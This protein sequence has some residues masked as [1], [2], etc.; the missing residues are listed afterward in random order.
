MNEEKKLSQGIKKGIAKAILWIFLILFLSLSIIIGALQ[1]S[2][3]QTKLADYG[4]DYLT[5]KTGFGFNIDRVNIKWLDQVAL[6]G[7]TVKDR[8]SSEFIFAKDLLINYK[9]KELFTENDILIDA[10]SL[11]DARLMFEREIGDRYFNIDHFADALRELGRS[12]STKKSRKKH[13]TIDDIILNNITLGVINK[14]EDSI[15]EGFDHTHF[16]LKEVYANAHQLKA[17]GDTI[18]VQVENLSCIDSASSLTLNNITTNFEIS[19]NAMKF[20]NMDLSVNESHITDSVVFTYNSMRDLSSFTDS[21]EFVGRFRETV[22]YAKDLAYFAPE[23]KQFSEQITL[24]GTIEGK[25]KNFDASDIYLAFGTNSFLKGQIS[26]D[27]LPYVAETFIN[28]NL[29]E[30]QL[31]PNDLKQYVNDSLANA[32]LKE[33]G[34]IGFKGDFLGFPQDFVANGVFTTAIGRI[35][36][37]LNLKV[38]ENNANTSYKGSISTFNLDLGKALGRD[39][40]FQKVQMTGKINGKGLSVETANVQL[41]ASFSLLGLKGYEYQ[42]I[43]TNA[44]LSSEFFNGKLTIDDPKLDL[45]VEGSI[46]LREGLNK[47][48]VTA[49]VDTVDLRDLNLAEKELI[50]KAKGV[51]NG[52]GIRIDSIVGTAFLEQVFI[53]YDGRQLELDTLSIFSAKSNKQRNFIINSDLFRSQ[54]E[55]EFNFTTLAKDIAKLEKEFEISLRNDE[56]EIQQYYSN[57]ANI[58]DTSNYSLDISLT[59]KKLNPLVNLFVPSLQLTDSSTVKG[60]FTKGKTSVLNLTAQFDTITYGGVEFHKNEVDLTFSKQADSTNVLG[61]AYIYSAHQ[62]LPSQLSTQDIES[63]FIWSNNTIEFNSFFQ[64]PQFNNSFEIDGAINFL[65]DSTSIKVNHSNLQA[66]ESQWFFTEENELILTNGDLIFKNLGIETESQQ[67]LVNG[68]LSEDPDK[69]LA[70]QI[71]SVE[72]ANVNSLINRTYEGTLQGFITVQDYTDEVIINGDLF[73]DEFKIDNFLIGDIRGKSSWS[74]IRKR[75]AMD[76][77]INR[78][79]KDIITLKGYY[80]PKLERNSLNIDARLKEANLLIG[81]PFISDIFS[82]IQGT[83]SGDFKISGTPDYPVV[84]GTGHISNGQLL[85]NYLNTPYTFNGNVTF[86]QDEINFDGLQI[87][88]QLNNT[89]TLEGALLHSGFTDLFLDLKGNMRNFNV[90]N[91]TRNDNSLYYGTAYATGTINFVGFANN[92]AIDATAISEKG[93]KIYIPVESGT[94]YEQEEFINFINI[95][96]SAVMEAD[97][98]NV[99]D[100]VD[101]NGINLDLDI[102]LTPD[103]YCEIIFDIKAGDIIRGR[104]N[105]KL[106]ML[107]NTEGD[108][109]MFGDYTIEEGG[110]NFTLYNIINKEFDIQQ[111]SKITWEGDPYGGILDI[112]AI[113]DQNVSL[114]PLLDTAYNDAPE[115]KRRYPA[116]VNLFLKGDL[117]KPQ[118]DFDVDV[119]GYPATITTEQGAFPL[120]AK[121]QAFKAELQANEQELKR[122]VFSLIILRRF[123][124]PESFAVSGSVGSS[125]SEFLS[126]QLSYWVT[127]FDENLE[128]DVDLGSFD[129]EAFNTFQ[130]R[131]SYSFLDGR[132]RVTRDGGFSTANANTVD[133]EILGILG[134]WSVEYLLTPDGKLRVKM[135]NQTNY[136]T[137]DRVNNSTT[138]ST[139]VSLVHVQSFDQLREIFKSQKKR[140]KEEEEKSE[141]EEPAVNANDPV[142]REDDDNS[143]D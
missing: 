128:I 137:I 77:D 124:P 119:N 122:Q 68:T 9:L 99:V 57:L 12:E 110:Y 98:I 138:T 31:D 13:L 136:N 21:V 90:L 44:Q 29:D 93:T 103:A 20:Q 54:L 82:N 2:I 91:T 123:S 107:I 45:N 141:Q 84:K 63:E 133:Q 4:S 60:S 66:L 42:N 109:N 80:E 70:I 108:F 46:D 96:D 129:D 23:L 56:Q 140:D 55:G 48:D 100:K 7:L 105:G 76:F 52:N 127:Q 132:L 135:Y 6:E 17:I 37:D 25:I 118:V 95:K 101:V 3:V 87:Q 43:V 51:L 18:Q 116:Q 32:R 64:Q 89:A 11:T 134:D 97:D 39:S 35:E 74:P 59:V 50:I 19:Q 24:T 139:G 40:L 58:E 1:S 117:L 85:V 112:T 71:D 113:Y 104:G 86:D 28:L 26:M 27:G 102:E 114:A 41:D 126:N 30:A 67:I 62:T 5:E 10:V 94:T 92:L 130:L 120:G 14:N 49:D 69:E 36:S 53:S 88:D 106:N 47:I 125:V 115:I 15:K 78:L 83:L 79:K 131:L 143:T 111:G 65:E 73:I 22:I 8:D 38:A 142:I 121:L 72:V 61:M 75:M 34:L 33:F 16:I 81:E